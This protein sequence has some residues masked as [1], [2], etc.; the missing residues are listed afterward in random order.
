MQ[1]IDTRKIG[2]ELRAALEGLG[3]DVDRIIVRVEPVYG[4]TYVRV[5]VRIRDQEVDVHGP[6]ESWPP[7]ASTARSL[8][9]VLRYGRET[10]L[11]GSVEDW[12]E[13]F[14]R[15]STGRNTDDQFLGLSGSVPMSER[16]DHGSL[17]PKRV[18][19]GQ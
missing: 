12:L 9:W 3:L 13:G 19:S 5:I 10:P 6:A 11:N 8:R 4:Q 7:A 14:R 2:T 18:M 15:I 16:N 1:A 17:P